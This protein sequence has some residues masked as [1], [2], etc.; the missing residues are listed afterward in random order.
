[1]VGDGWP[2]TDTA[3]ALASSH[4][5]VEHEIPAHFPCPHTP[6][7]PLCGPSTPRPHQINPSLALSKPP[8]AP[9]GPLRRTA[10]R[11]ADTRTERTG[12]LRGQGQLRTVCRR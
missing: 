3:S 4:G 10:D 9:G 5:G 2:Y 7:L 1:M 8:P 11:H 12:T 6:F